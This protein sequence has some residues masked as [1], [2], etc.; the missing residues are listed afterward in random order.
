MN[1]KEKST[2]CQ[3]GSPAS[4]LVLPGSAEA[5]KMTDTSGRKCLEAFGKL[6]RGGSWAKTF[7]DLLVGTT[8]WYS[9]RC[10][11]TWK[12]KD[13]P[14]K[15]SYFLLQVSV[16]RTGETGY[17]LLPTPKAREANDSPSER[18]RKQPSLQALAAMRLLP[19]PAAQDAKNYTLPQSQR[20]GHNAGLR[21]A[22]FARFPVFEPGL[23]RRHDGFPGKLDNCTLSAW[24]GGAIR[25]YGNAVVP[26]LVKQIFEAID[27]YEL[28]YA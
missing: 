23:R 16:P 5:Q 28:I 13:T 12:L 1:L 11:L 3:E 15:R 4:H 9:N 10:V 27:T 14:F 25:G 8:G 2:Y 18:M 19:T 22:D 17:S 24:Y 6:S 7:A 26:Q 21:L 20:E